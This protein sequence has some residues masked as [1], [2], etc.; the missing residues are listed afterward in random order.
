[1]SFATKGKKNVQKS[2]QQT[3]HTVLQK[4]SPKLSHTP[5]MPICVKIERGFLK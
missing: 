1:M 2:R 5:L 3:P 4:L